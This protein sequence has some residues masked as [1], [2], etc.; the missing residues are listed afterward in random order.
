MKHAQAELERL[1]YYDAL[2]NI[3]NRLLLVSGLGHAIERA[4]RQNGLGAVLFVD[5]DGFKPVNDSLGHKAGDELLQA[6]AHRLT[7]RQ[8]DS[9]T[10]GRLG[11]DEFVV[12]LEEIK[13][14]Q[15]V[16]S[17][18]QEII[19]RLNAPCSLASTIPVSIGASIGI[20]IFPW[21]GD[22]ATQ[23]IEN[24]DQALY[25]AKRAGRGVFKFFNGSL[26]K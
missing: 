9:D 2:T 26:F 11:G 23:L 12:V 16:A 13:D 25:E 17:V 3:A 22:T 8:R 14:S 21:D 5:L 20:A 6:V 15:D 7:E 18:A 10:V 4:K 1:A 24:A 19:D